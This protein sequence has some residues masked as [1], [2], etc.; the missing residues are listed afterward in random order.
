MAGIRTSSL[1][2]PWS[3]VDS[4]RICAAAYSPARR[5][6]KRNAM[7]TVVV[8]AHLPPTPDSIRIGE[9]AGSPAY[10]VSNP[11]TINTLICP[12]VVLSSGQ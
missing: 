9:A 2:T 7:T 5:G 6:S 4:A 1:P 10:G 11:R 3:T 12:R 8:T